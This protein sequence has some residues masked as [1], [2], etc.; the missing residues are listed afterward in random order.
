MQNLYRH[1]WDIEVFFKWIKQNIVVKTL[2]GFSKNAVSTHL[3][4]A[5]ITYLLIAKMKHEYKSPY[6]IT[7]VATLIRISVL[8]K[9]NLKELITK[10]DP[11]PS[12]NQ[13]VKE[14]S[15]FDDI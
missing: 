15:L 4:V 14:R 9:V 3:W 10:Q 12:H 1:R 11:L 6:S 8:E 13:Y 5:I 2:W 7:E